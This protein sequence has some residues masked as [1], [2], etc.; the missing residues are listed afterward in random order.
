MKIAVWIML[1]L[2]IVFGALC[3][4]LIVAT[5]FIK[6]QTGLLMAMAMTSLFL[7]SMLFA[8]V[9]FTKER[10][11]SGDAKALV[12]ISTLLA[13]SAWISYLADIYG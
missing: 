13:F 4:A 7:A 2:G 12:L 8:G 11:A 6:G 5:S 9:D 10:R 3:C 1:V